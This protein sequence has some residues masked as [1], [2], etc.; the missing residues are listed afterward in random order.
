MAII[1]WDFDNTLAYRDGMWTRS[2]YNV[3]KNNGYDQISE[4]DIRPHFREGFPW[5]RYEE[6]HKDY[7]E[8]RTWWEYAN[9]IIKQA[10][11]I[12]GVADSEATV[13]STQFKSEYLD[14]QKWNLFDDTIRNLEE[15]SRRGHYN[16]ILSNHV[17]ELSVLVKGLSI[18]KYFSK[19]IS[20]AEVGYEKPN[21]MIFKELFKY[22][23]HESKI[24]MIGD[25]YAADV[26]GAIKCGFDA[27]LV[28][29]DNKTNYV[30]YSVD[31][32]GIWKYIN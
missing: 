23:D 9:T 11:L 25:S 5:H 15:S 8:G 6:S 28:R 12:N 24:Y 13:L 18:D 32:D 3:L 14:I 30:N 2:L 1:V 29:Q 17:P 21:T 22:I 20:S 31:L 7:F 27:I 19:V 26:Q 10:L 16:Y 4:D